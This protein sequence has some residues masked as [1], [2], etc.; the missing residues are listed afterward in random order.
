[1]WGFKKEE[2]LS[3]LRAFRDEVLVDSEVGRNYLCMLYNNSL[4]V[5]TLLIRNPSLTEE[6]KEG[7]DKLL[8][9]IQ[10][11]LDGGEMI[12]SKR[13]LASIESLLTR[14]ESEATPGLKTAIKKVRRDISAEKVFKQLRINI[15]E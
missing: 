14:F 4:E 5:L 2:N 11:V 6:T 10:S 1:M 13:Q 3:L 9:K 15:V 12:F 7:I 8:P